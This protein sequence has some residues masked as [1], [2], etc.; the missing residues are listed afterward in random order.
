MTEFRTKMSEN[1]RITIPALCREQ[2]HLE[3]GKDLIIRIDNEE[4]RIFSVEHSLRKAQKL[5]QKYAKNKSLL[6]QLKNMR[7]EDSRNE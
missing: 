3:P 2:L 7:S 1:G 4:M 5:V 6:K